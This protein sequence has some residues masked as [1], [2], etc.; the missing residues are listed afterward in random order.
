MRWVLHRSVGIV[1]AQRRALG[2]FPVNQ[3]LPRPGLFRHQFFPSVV[4][5]LFRVQFSGE[6]VAE[7][8]PQSR[9]LMGAFLFTVDKAM[10]S[11]QR[12]T[13]TST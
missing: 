10:P 1:M 8:S 6:T 13:A 4:V 5:V 2:H 12:A 3:A 7:P 9:L 11:M